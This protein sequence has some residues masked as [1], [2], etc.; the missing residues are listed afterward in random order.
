M[1]QNSSSKGGVGESE[2]CAGRYGAGRTRDGSKRNAKGI[3]DRSASGP[4][5]GVASGAVAAMTFALAPSRLLPGLGLANRR[6]PCK[7]GVRMPLSSNVYGC[8]T[9]LKMYRGTGFVTLPM[10]TRTNSHPSWPYMLS[11]CSSL[12][13]FS[14]G[15]DCTTRY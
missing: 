3:M 9:R 11:S 14:W 15:R 5:V 7:R 2:I 4:A 10:S 8:S 1:N 12:V 13:L 6:R